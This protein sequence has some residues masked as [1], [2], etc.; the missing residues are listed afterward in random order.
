MPDTTPS[1]TET[2]EPIVDE[3]NDMTGS[4][5]ERAQLVRACLADPEG[6][7]AALSAV[8]EQ[9]PDS[10][11]ARAALDLA[12]AAGRL[13]AASAGNVSLSAV[14]SEMATGIVGDGDLEAG[15]APLATPSTRSAPTRPGRSRCRC[16]RR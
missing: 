12:E 1:D 6:V 9:Q 7:R 13:E 14:L 10:E 4:A 15:A 8:L 16:A 11:I 3:E 5:G 2:L